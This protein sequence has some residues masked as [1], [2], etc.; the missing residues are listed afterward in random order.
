MLEWPYCGGGKPK[1][2]K[3]LI[4]RVLMT[5]PGWA[6]AEFPRVRRF[7]AFERRGHFHCRLLS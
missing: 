6:S 1:K 2:G 4:P 5:Y 3:S 7:A